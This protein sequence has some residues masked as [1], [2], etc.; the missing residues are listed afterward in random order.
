MIDA[1]YV[2]R[3]LDTI[4]LCFEEEEYCILRIAI[5]VIISCLAF[6]MTAQACTY[7]QVNDSWC[8]RCHLPITMKI[9]I[10]I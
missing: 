1:T 8:R 5:V 4:I 7:W 2:E 3:T 10:Y 9:C 6:R